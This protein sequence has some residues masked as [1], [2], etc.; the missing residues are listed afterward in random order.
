MYH[1]GKL[2]HIQ[3]KLYQEVVKVLGK[4]GDVTSKSLGKL[5]YLKACLKESMRYNSLEI[6][7][8]DSAQR[9]SNKCKKYLPKNYS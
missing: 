7:K 3:E 9:S 1:L 2:P 5:P 6:L 8:T 4:D